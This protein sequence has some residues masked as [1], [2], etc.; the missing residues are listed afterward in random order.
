MDRRRTP[1]ISVLG[2]H[3]MHLAF[4]HDVVW[5]PELGLKSGYLVEQI[6]E[7]KYL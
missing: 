3:V 7:N 6:L 1:Q 5:K 4:L 2:G